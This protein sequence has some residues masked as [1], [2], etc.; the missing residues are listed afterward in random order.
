METGRVTGGGGYSH[1][2]SPNPTNDFFIVSGLGNGEEV[3]LFDLSGRRIFY[4]AQV[5]SESIRIDLSSFTTG[6]YRLIIDHEN[7]ERYAENI[8]K[9]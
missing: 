9:N 8:F 6:V 7:Q 3:S 2:V 5:S 1:T 4:N